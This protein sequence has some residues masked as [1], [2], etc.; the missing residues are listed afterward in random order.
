VQ[1]LQAEAAAEAIPWKSPR[2]WLK[3]KNLSRGFWVFFTAA[4]FFDFGFAVYFFLFNLYLL[5]L[6]FDERTIGLVGG[7][8][9]LGSVAGT[10][11]AGVLA[12]RIGIRPLLI[13]CFVA[14]PVFGSLRAVAVGERSQI[15]LAFLAGLAMCLW[16]VCFLPAV[17]R[18]TTEK[19][20]PSAFSLIFSVSIGTSTLGGI[21]CGYL[22]RW[23]KSAG[24]T[25]Q[26]A[27]VKR[28]ILLT[29][30]GIAAAGLLAVLRIRLPLETLS[31]HATRS[32]GWRRIWRLDPFLWRFLPSMALWTAVLAA[33]TPFAN[34]YLAHQLHV[35][36]LRIGLVF[37]AAHIVQL[38][39]GLLTPLLFRKLGM[40]NGI[41]ATQLATAT[42]MACLAGIHATG[43]SIALYLGFS[44]TQ[45]MSNPGLYNL[46]MDQVPDQQRSTASAITMFLNALAGSGAT[47]LSGILFARFGYPPVLAGIAALAVVAA[48]LFRSLVG[49]RANV[50]G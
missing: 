48:A 36:L 29:S 4:F 6:H 28:M 20:R 26:P 18:L 41:V 17:A 49:R 8:L 11:P 5:D 10:L 15:G 24:F 44:A 9:T 45:W 34:V 32:A 42:A 3:A 31:K 40:V 35:P 14:A 27:E 7:A 19:N 22:P 21:L 37:S 43:L 2:A 13:V 47:A 46:L 39:A 16:G 50:R 12:R 25:M 33:F 1:L 38:C 30:C 23:L